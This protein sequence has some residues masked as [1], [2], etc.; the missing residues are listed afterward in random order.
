MYVVPIDGL[1]LRVADPDWLDPLDPTLAAQPPGQRWNPPGLP[2][3]YLNADM[4]T[5]RANVN[6]LYDGLPYGPEDLD[7]AEAPI[8]IEVSIPRGTAA[9]ALGNSGLLD[10]GLPASYP[11]DGGAGIVSHAIC[12]PIGRAAFDAGLDGVAARSA[13]PGGN[14]ELAWFP[15]GLVPTTVATMRFEDWW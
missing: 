9:D 5:A 13:A 1:N 15:R 8:L 10:M 14:R 3:L 12:Q 6:R 11:Q 2:C 7:P 4:I